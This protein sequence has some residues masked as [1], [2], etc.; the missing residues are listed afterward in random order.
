M[1]RRAL[2]SLSKAA[3]VF[4]LERPW[5]PLLGPHPF[6]LASTLLVSGVAA[7]GCDVD[8]AIDAGANRGQF[9]AA[10]LRRFPHAKVFAFEPNPHVAMRFRRALRHRPN[11][12][13]TEIALT[14]RVGT[15]QLFVP[16]NDQT[17]TIVKPPT[18]EVRTIEVR[19]S[20]L[21]QELSEVPLCSHSLLKLDLQGAELAALRGATK[22]LGA[23]GA[24]VCEIAVGR[25]GGSTGDWSA[26]ASL[27]ESAGFVFL[28]PLALLRSFT[29][30]VV[31]MDAFFVK[32]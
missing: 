28:G 9:T 2:T 20:T 32:V 10:V 1:I 27:L 30:E 29:G 6:S 16:R 11:V 7:A 3:D 26:I 31:Q 13:V 19:T 17:A 12:L 8:L 23:V 15:A 24:V 4:A 21:D 5:A 18:T 25:S 22:V 14:D